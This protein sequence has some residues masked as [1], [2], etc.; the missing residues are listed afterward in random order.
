MDNH[1]K[2][3]IRKLASDK[4]DH[5]TPISV[6]RDY[7]QDETCYV[8]VSQNG[9]FK[10]HIPCTT[11]PKDLEKTENLICE[12]LESLGYEVSRKYLN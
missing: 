4:L 10:F 6:Q 9:D 1:T 8:Y 2:D 12:T 5:L 11:D 7:V 3:I